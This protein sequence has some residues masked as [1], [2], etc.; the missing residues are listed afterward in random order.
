MIWLMTGSGGFC[1]DSEPCGWTFFS[2][3]PGNLQNINTNVHCSY[4]NKITG[5]NAHHYIHEL[6]SDIETGDSSTF[7]TVNISWV[8][9]FF[10]GNFY[11]SAYIKV[12]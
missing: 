11:V 8:V 9:L 3:G 12:N 5:F 4:L 7:T 10:K 1:L 6:K 2:P